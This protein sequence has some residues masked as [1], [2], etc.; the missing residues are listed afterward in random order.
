LVFCWS[1]DL[2]AASQSP[3]R[4]WA[5]RGTG[6][7]HSAAPASPAGGLRTGLMTIAPPALDAHAAG[8]IAKG[9][10]AEAA[11]SYICPNPADVKDAATPDQSPLTYRRF[12][13]APPALDAHAAGSI[14][15]GLRAEAALSYICPNPADVKDAATPD[16]SPLTYR[17][18]RIAPPAL[19]AH[20]AGSIAK[21]LRAEA[22]LSYICPNPADVE[23][24][25]TPDQSAL[26]CRRFRIAPPALDAQ[27]AGLV[28][29]GLRAEAAL[30]C[31]C[32]NPADV[33]DHG[34]SS[35]I[36]SRRFRVAAPGKPSTVSCIHEHR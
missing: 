1:N 36:T 11:L 22:A 10:R 14:A 15:K 23:D 34:H 20:A 17:R 24:A 7:R 25:A 19:D 32:P 27:A 5:F 21:G 12:R 33:K 9:L 8:S 31:I 6:T 3:L 18:F 2:S 28:A 29:K 30:S 13:I 35:P 4:G 26:T 16:Q